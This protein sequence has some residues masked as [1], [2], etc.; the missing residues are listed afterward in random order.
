MAT[1]SKSP[2]MR[3][4]TPLTTNRGRGEDGQTFATGRQTAKRNQ[5]IELVSKSPLTSSTQGTSVLTG[6]MRPTGKANGFSG[7][8]KAAGAARTS[9]TPTKVY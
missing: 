7:A 1:P 9:V 3:Q 2:V 5:K 6:Q 4:S 8:V